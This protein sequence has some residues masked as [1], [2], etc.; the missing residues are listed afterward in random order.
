MIFCWAIAYNCQTQDLDSRNHLLDFFPWLPLHDFFSGLCCEDFK[1]YPIPTHPT[2]PSKKIVCPLSQFLTFNPNSNQLVY[3]FCC[4]T[5]TFGC[6]WQWLA[7]RDAG[8]H[9]KQWR[10][11]VEGLWQ[12]KIL[13]PHNVPSSFSFAHVLM[14]CFALQ[15]LS[16]YQ[17][18]LLPSESFS[19]LFD[20]AGV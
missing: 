1:K 10:D 5:E 18:D 14:S 12:G 17:T 11:R 6:W 15:I 20:V 9:S 7:A 3:I 13:S 8:S 16:F 19:E 4:Y 2:H